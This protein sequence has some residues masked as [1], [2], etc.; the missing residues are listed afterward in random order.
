MASLLEL[1]PRYYSIHQMYK[2]DGFQE[3][4]MEVL[5]DEFPNQRRLPMQRIC[6]LIPSFC[7]LEACFWEG[8]QDVGGSNTTGR[9]LAMGKEP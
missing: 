9:F 4:D 2:D 6:Y 7:L 3:K 1:S 5:L 8:R